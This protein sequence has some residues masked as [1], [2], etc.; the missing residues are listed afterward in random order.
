MTGLCLVADK[1]AIYRAHLTWA[2]PPQI[3]LRPRNDPLSRLNGATPTRA[4]IW[5]RLRLPSSG[6]DAI[7]LAE[8][9]GPTPGTLCKRLSLTRHIGLSS[10]HFLRSISISLICRFS[11]LIWSSIFFQTDLFAVCKRFFSEVSIRT[12]CSWRVTRSVSR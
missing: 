5:R 10:I 11:H 6:R 1:T 9:L 8:V 3:V 2:R 12:N 7:S 4:A